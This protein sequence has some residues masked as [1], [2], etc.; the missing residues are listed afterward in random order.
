MIYIIIS[1]IGLALMMLIVYMRYSKFRITS[2]SE[3]KE[4]RK[5]LDAANEERKAIEG[6]LL[7]GTKSESEKVEKLLREI[8]EARKEKEG[9]IKLRLEAEKQVELALQK[10]EEI[11]KRMRDW[12]VVQDAVMKDSK[13]AIM[14]VGNDLFKKLS[15]SYKTEVET[16]KNLI[17][18]IAKSI[19]EFGEKFHHTSLPQNSSNA[20]KP[21]AP[22]LS[23][24]AD[25][26]LALDLVNIM[27]ASGHM[28]NKNYFVPANFDEQKA[29]LFFCEVAFV[30]DDILYVMDFKAC[31]FLEQKNMAADSRKQ[32][33]DKYLSYLKNP[34][35]LESILKVMA[36]T[37]AKFSEKRIIMVVPKKEDLQILKEIGIYQKAEQAK[38]EINEFDQINNIVI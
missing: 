35:Y 5:K 22:T 7:T 16:N 6:S 19:S 32:A 15:D 18:R 38:I 20:A 24:I 3:I 26:K 2:G 17:G 27:K 28:V 33:L 12:R 30:G 11:Q 21:S 8:D 34:K 29:R 23:A 9:E 25:N 36:T 4:L 14:K 13:D 31:R 1:N 10:I 37:Q